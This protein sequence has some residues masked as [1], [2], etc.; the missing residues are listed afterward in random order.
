MLASPT[1]VARL[2]LCSVYANASAADAVRAL[3][4]KKSGVSRRGCGYQSSGASLIVCP[5][6]W[7]VLKMSASLLTKALP[8]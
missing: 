2:A 4:S 3:V 6:P 5:R 7:K 8:R 1:T